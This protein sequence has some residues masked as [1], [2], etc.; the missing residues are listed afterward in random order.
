MS[1]V[2][3]IIA[4]LGLILLVVY[5]LVVVLVAFAAAWWP[6]ASAGGGTAMEETLASKALGGPLR[7]TVTLPEGYD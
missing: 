4:F 5:A 2:L 7:F 3:A 1:S 6:G